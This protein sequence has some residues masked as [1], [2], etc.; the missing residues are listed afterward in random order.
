M[1]PRGPALTLRAMPARLRAHAPF[2]LLLALSVALC[3]WGLGW[4]LP[5]RRGWA[6]DELLPQDVL[7]GLEQCFSGGWHERYPPLHY[8]ALALAYAPLLAAQPL[9]EPPLPLAQQ[10]QLLR[11]GRALSLVFWA[12]LL[13]GVYVL[14]RELLGGAG[15]LLAAL[16]SALV[17]PFVYYAKLANLEVPYLCWWAWSL[18]F[19]VRALAGRRGATLPLLALLATLAVTTKDQ[20]YGLFA[21]LPLPVLAQR[22]PG[23][24]WRAL[25]SREVALAL[26]TGLLAFALVHDLA[27]NLD[28]FR[29]HVATLLAS[30]RAFRAFAPG[31]AGQL[32]LLAS[33]GAG[34]AFCLGWPATLLALAGLALAWRARELPLLGLLVP[35]LSYHLTFLAVVLYCYDRF[36]LPWA[37]LGTLFAA[38]A[39]QAG[40]SGGRLA[41]GAAVLALALCA[42]TGLARAVS[43]NLHMS[44]DG[45][46]DVEAW[47]VERVRP[48]DD[49]GQTAPAQA[50]PRLRAEGLRAVGPDVEELERTQPRFV[51]VNPAWSRGTE[52]G[53]AERAFVER[54]ERGQLPYRLAVEH[55]WQAPAFLPFDPAALDRPGSRVV[56]NL[57]K[58]NPLLR[59]YERL[60]PAS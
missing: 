18:L 4:G 51:V 50:M 58:V 24:R 11:A 8:Y 60:E 31:L 47:L 37:L 19:Y 32:E 25:L 42:W 52:A 59:V 14:G 39:L 29:A 34:L 57:A 20:A 30:G 43:L 40:L 2:A 5:S 9:P 7:S 22:W 46:Q 23:A 36:V 13:T 54:L 56:S 35:A 41:R 27:F 49:V 48:G 3:A 55:R 53:S 12:G 10:E 21:L 6:P 17:L 38:R 28:G 45:R 1:R 16:L 33:A 26:A 15:G 44:H